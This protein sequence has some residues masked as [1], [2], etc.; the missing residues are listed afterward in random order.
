M[1][2]SGA[3]VGFEGDVARFAARGPG[4][5]FVDADAAGFR[6]IGIVGERGEADEARRDGFEAILGES[7]VD[8]G[9]R[10][11]W[12][13]L[14]GILAAALDDFLFEVREFRAEDVSFFEE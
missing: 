4:F 14:F 8:L 2:D 1:R 12:E 13:E 10:C 5:E 3:A 9:P 11:L 7:A 6:G